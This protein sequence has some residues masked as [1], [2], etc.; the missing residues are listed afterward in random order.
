[1]DD[2]E[3]TDRRQTAR[4]VREFVQRTAPDP[5]AEDVQPGDRWRT[6]KFGPTYIFGKDRQ[7]WLDN[8]DPQL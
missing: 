7:W 2:A 8:G 1:M 6:R 3:Q 4:P 5:D